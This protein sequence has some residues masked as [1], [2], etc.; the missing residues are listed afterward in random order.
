MIHPSQRKRLI[1]LFVLVLAGLPGGGLSPARPVWAAEAGTTRVLRFPADR[2][3]GSLH[4]PNRPL[5]LS[6]KYPG[7]HSDDGWVYF[8]EATGDVTVP[9]DKKIR[10]NI[11]AAAFNDLSPAFQAR[12][13][14]SLRVGRVRPTVVLD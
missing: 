8:G 3:L 4:V 10:L 7:R 9:A 14:R 5:K 11:N 12:V 6:L 2:S 13:E 1:P